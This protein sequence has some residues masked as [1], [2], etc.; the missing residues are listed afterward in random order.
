MSCSIR[1]SNL[2]SCISFFNRFGGSNG[3][4]R[5]FWQLQEQQ[6]THAW[7][8]WTPLSSVFL[9]VSEGRGYIP[10]GLSSALFVLTSR[11][12]WLSAVPHFEWK[13]SAFGSVP[14]FRVR[15][16]WWFTPQSTIVWNPSPQ[17]P[18]LGVCWF[19]P[20]PRP[21]IPHWE[22]LVPRITLGLT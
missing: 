17:S 3:I 5:D 9:I 7:S 16:C 22:L 4:K 6:E 14:K 12:N 11:Y 13:T 20:F 18:L 1:P 10:L 8:P 2:L 15:T 19:S 21:Q